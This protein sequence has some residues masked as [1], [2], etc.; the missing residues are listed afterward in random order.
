MKIK[1]FMPLIQMK[2]YR[3]TQTIYRS[4]NFYAYYT[5]NNP[6]INKKNFQTCGGHGCSRD[7]EELRL[8]DI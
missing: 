8:P 3:K 2:W 4:Y 5:L 1:Q 6:I 7:V